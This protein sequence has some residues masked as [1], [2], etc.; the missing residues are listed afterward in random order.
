MILV[1]DA[2]DARITA[3]PSLPEPREIEPRRI[4][5]RIRTGQHVQLAIQEEGDASG[6]SLA[7]LIL[8]NR[9]LQHRGELRRRVKDNGDS[10][11]A[12]ALARADGCSKSQCGSAG[13]ERAWPK[14]RN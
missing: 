14:L 12:P 9:I 6:L 4:H 10:A 8:W 11:N 2:Q 5:C 3:A 7:A 13:V 1:A